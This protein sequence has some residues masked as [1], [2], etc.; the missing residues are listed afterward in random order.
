MY[1]DILIVLIKRNHSNLS[2]CLL[3]GLNYNVQ[4]WHF[5]DVKDVKLK[6]KKKTDKRK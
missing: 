5:I 2:P 1:S 4:Q 6:K 3:D